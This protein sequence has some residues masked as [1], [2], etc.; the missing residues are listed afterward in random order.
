MK[1]LRRVFVRLCYTLFVL[2]FSLFITGCRRTDVRE[3]TV[4]IPGLCETNQATVVAA[5]ARY[6]GID[7]SSYVWNLDKKTLTLKYDSMKLAQSNVRYS[8]DEAGIKVE[9]PKKEGNHAGY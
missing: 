7:K 3:M 8:I 5:L 4:K 2:H 1:N 6:E 9:F